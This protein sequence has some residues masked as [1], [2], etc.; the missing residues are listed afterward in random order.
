MFTVKQLSNLA[1][2][3]PR[4]LHYYDEIGLLKPE[5]Y[6][7]HG[8]RFYG[9]ESL[10]RLQ[11]ILYFRELDFSLVEI[12]AITGKPDFDVLQALNTHRLALG[13]RVK[14]LESL[15]HTVDK[16]I[17]HYQGELEMDQEEV[18]EG[19]SDAKRKE[20]E[21]E[22]R[23]RYGSAVVDDSVKR[24]NSYPKEKK[25]AI[26]AEMGAIFKRIT[27]LIPKGPESEA[28][29]EEIAKLHAQMN[30]FY[31]CSLERF[32]GLGHLY[33]QHPD[34]IAMYQEKYHTDMPAF[35][36]QAIMIYVKG[37]GREKK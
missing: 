20:Y 11:Q 3:S 24:W 13:D 17:L 16:T 9:E 5:A 35:L 2:V 32:E 18:F 36:E 27:T 21:E 7:E 31:E 30:Y 22:M 23:A 12:R 15:I 25:A 8:Y 4:T 28:V 34:F 26:Q 14:R 29:Q 1:G 33:N 10:L 6:G 19:F 37:K